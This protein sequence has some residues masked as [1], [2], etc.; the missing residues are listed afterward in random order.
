MEVLRYKTYYKLLCTSG[1]LD[2]KNKNRQ[3]ETY[4]IMLND[5]ILHHQFNLVIFLL[6]KNVT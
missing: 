4:Q 3:N 6:K 1:I 5:V 2:I